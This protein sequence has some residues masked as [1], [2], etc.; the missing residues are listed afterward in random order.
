MVLDR[1][2]SRFHAVVGGVDPSVVADSGFAETLVG[3]FGHFIRFGGQ[4]VRV[5]PFREPFSIPFVLDVVELVVGHSRLYP[6]GAGALFVGKPCGAAVEDGG[7]VACGLDRLGHLLQDDVQPA[8]FAVECE[9]AAVDLRQDRIAAFGGGDQQVALLQV[10]RIDCR[11]PCCVADR[12]DVAD[13]CI[14][15]GTGRT[16]AV[17]ENAGDRSCV[18]C[19]QIGIVC[20]EFRRRCGERGRRG[21]VGQFGLLTG[22]DYECNGDDKRSEKSFIWFHRRIFF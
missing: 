22:A 19:R 3:I 1:N 14:A 9:G 15:A 12:H 4:T 20:D 6:F 10:D 18:A 8:R 7:G 17:A 11:T 16:V 2:N 21:G 5:C 13:D